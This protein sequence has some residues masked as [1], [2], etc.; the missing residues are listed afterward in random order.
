MEKNRL[1]AFSDGVMAIIITIM[2]LELKIPEGNDLHSLLSLLPMF[3]IYIL[4][5]IYIGLYWNNHH[6]LFHAAASINSKIMWANLY[7]LFWL[8][9]IPV[10]T[11]W[12][13]KNPVAQWPAA[14]YGFILL[15]SAIGHYYLVHLVVKMNDCQSALSM[16]LGKDWKGRISLILYTLGIIFSFINNLIA[17]LIY[18]GVTLLWITPDT[19]LIK[20]TTTL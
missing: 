9:L 10:S 13:G 4:S 5:F 19:R 11:G 15:M 1:E 7:L 6:N 8:S 17:F 20:K 12:V 2:V 16:S 18:F 14:F 3:L